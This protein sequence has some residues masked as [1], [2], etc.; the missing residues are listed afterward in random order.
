MMGT[1]TT[2]SDHIELDAVEFWGQ[3]LYGTALHDW[4]ND[5]GAAA[6]HTDLPQ[7]TT[8]DPSQPHNY[9]FLW[10]PAT[11]S[12]PGRVEFYY[13]GKDVGGET[14]SQ[15]G[16][17]SVLDASHLV[18]ILGTGPNNPM[19]V[20]NVQVWQTSAANDL[21]NGS[22]AP[23]TPPDTTPPVVTP[24]V[25]TPPDTTPPVTTPPG[26]IPPLGAPGSDNFTTL[27]DTTDIPTLL[28]V[29]NGNALASS[30][31]GGFPITLDPGD[32]TPGTNGSATDAQ[33]NVYT[34]PFRGDGWGDTMGRVAMNGVVSDELGG[35]FVDAIR[36]VNGVALFENSKGLGWGNADTNVGGDP[37][38]GDPGSSTGGLPV[39]GTVPPPVITPPDTT[40]PVVTPPDTIPPVVA[41][42]VGGTPSANDTV[43]LAGSTDAITDASGNL[44]TITGG[45]QIAVNGVTDAV[46]AEVT[47]LAY[48]DG[49]IWQENT[50]GNWYGET[51]PDDSW[52]AATTTSPLPAAPSSPPTTTPSPAVIHV[53][54]HKVHFSVAATSAIINATRGNHLFFISGS[55]DT[56]N[57]GGG[58]ETITDSGEGGNTFNLP[59]AGNG[60]A[61]F[62]AAVLTDGDV[63]NLKAA[64]AE[65]AW[66]GS[67]ST[68]SSFLHTEQ[69][70]A[71]TELL[72]SE[73]SGGTGVLLATFK[74]STAS[75]STIL[76]H[77]VT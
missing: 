36:I 62:N 34:L 77:S 54:A 53:P 32:I 10:V 3:N 14:Y 55:N 48:V 66:T 49:T 57:L 2:K 25:V 12:T 46:T 47:R 60:S 74:D 15:G 1:D 23:V 43:V 56:F 9:G 73:Q 11:A 27:P 69:V 61:V 68:L 18:L 19:T 21:I 13:D 41:P 33:G 67:P 52:S 50:A 7:V 8:G 76:D 17:Y 29:M 42:P 44:W 40:P 72:V 39:Q 22:A 58:A 20:S 24:P 63:F 35:G 26:A 51:R 59:A 37:G 64:L 28:A 30:E 70:G 71:N 16:T 6:E 31:S 65:T 75:L 45:A 5:G 38:P 4:P